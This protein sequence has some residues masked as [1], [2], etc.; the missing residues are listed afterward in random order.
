M[1]WTLGER[2]GLENIFI[3]P[4]LPSCFNSTLPW[5]HSLFSPGSG[6]KAA[7]YPI[8]REPARVDGKGSFEL[9]SQMLGMCGEMDCVSLPWLLIPELSPTPEI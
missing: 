3:E 4:N 8:K 6:H 1:T 7:A 2:L 9:R 5:P